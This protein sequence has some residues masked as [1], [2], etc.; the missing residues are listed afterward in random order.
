MLKV[1]LAACFC[2]YFYVL[3]LSF[4]TSNK[5]LSVLFTNQNRWV[6]TPA[7]QYPTEMEKCLTGNFNLPNPSM[8]AGNFAH[9]SC[10][11]SLHLP[12]GSRT[13]LSAP[14]L[15][16]LSFPASLASQY[17]PT[18]RALGYP[19]VQDDCLK[20]L[21]RSPPNLLDPFHLL[22]DSI[23]FPVPLMSSCSHN[24]K[25]HEMFY[26]NSDGCMTIIRGKSMKRVPKGQFPL[27]LSG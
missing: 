14:G 8:P 16:S 9:R 27:W 19:E 7:T 18:Q 25:L 24:Y 2:S 21:V 1:C 12:E 15:P 3:S 20:H 5:I 22:S 17:L 4:W 23:F 6:L 10:A 26:W 13:G 11:Q